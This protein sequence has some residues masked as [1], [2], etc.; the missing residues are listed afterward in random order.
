MRL[1]TDDRAALLMAQPFLAT[2]AMQLPIVAVVDDRLRTSCTDGR[3]LFVSAPL[4]VA[5]KPLERRFVLAHAVWH[6]A[7]L[8]PWRRRQHRSPWWDLAIDHEVNNILQAVLPLP[9][10]AA[11]F[12]AWQDRSAEQV[13]RELSGMA[14]CR[15]RGR[16]ADLH[17]GPNV[18]GTD[19]G[20]RPPGAE[21]QRHD[22]RFVPRLDRAS[23]QMWAS[24]IL[25]AAGQVERWVGQ[26][27]GSV[28]RLIEGLRQPELP[29]R[30]WLRQFVVSVVGDRRAWLPPSRRHLYQG[31]YLPSRREEALR[32]AVAV[33]TSASTQALQVMFLSEL[34]GLVHAYG[35][36]EMLLVQGDAKVQ[37]V[38]TYTQDEP[39]E[40]TKLRLRGFG[41]TDFRPVFR[42]LRE[43]GPTPSALVFMTDGQG[44]AP[45]QPPGYPVLWALPQGGRQPASWGSVVHLDAPTRPISEPMP[46]TG[47]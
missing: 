3:S 22:P 44:V 8:H 40:P 31:L 13:Y 16:L 14:E 47:E 17:P 10:D 42:H 12:E 37:H 5:L 18:A 35:R 38:S 19:T 41:G 15:G 1:L 30:D 24:R 20:T 36:Y 45:N 43:H 23:H 6:L 39:L 34:A 7:L 29:W 28:S 4:I 25:A 26:L 21:A 33:D 2:L 27:P 9:M 32:I 46:Q 11:W